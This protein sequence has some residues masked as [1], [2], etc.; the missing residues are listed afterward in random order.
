MTKDREFVMLIEKHKGILYKICHI[1]ERKDS[2]R[3]DLFQEIVV[4]LWKSYDSFN[5]KSQ[6]S[7]WMYRVGLNTSIARL[8]KNDKRPKL[9]SIKEN[10]ISIAYDDNSERNQQMS[11]LNKAITYLND[12]EKALIFLYLE[13][14]SSKEIAE[15]LGISEVNARVR[16]NR[17]KG[18]LKDIINKLENM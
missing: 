2:E 17:V 8:R 11:L 16:L 18:K 1:Y 12:L 6:F 4:Q 10:S 5:G 14:K 9:E 7:T 3:Q 15:T 13:D